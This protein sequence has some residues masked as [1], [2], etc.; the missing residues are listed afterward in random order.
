ME[1]PVIPISEAERAQGALTQA[2]AFAAITA[3]HEA[4]SVVLRGVFAADYIDA[5][6]REFAARYDGLDLSAM[7]ALA[8]QPPPNPIQQVGNGRFEIAL[9]MNGVFGQPSLFANPV[10]MKF[11]TPLLG[12]NMMRLS[13]VTAV[14][15][16]PGAAAQHIHRDHQQL[17]YEFAQIG[18]ALPLY[19]VNVS[20]P[21]IDIDSVT[22]PTGIW[23]GSHRWPEQQKATAEGMASIPF[24]RGDCVLIDYRTMH[25][26]LPN[27][28]Q[29]V[30]PILYLVYSREWFFDDNNHRGRAPLDISAEQIRLLAPELHPLMMRAY[31]QGGI[32]GA[33]LRPDN[34]PLSRHNPHDPFCQMA[35]N[36]RQAIGSRKVRAPRKDGAG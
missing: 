34:C 36:H 4:G 19:G 13:S 14:A 30:R 16:F 21:L 22:G 9:R 26:G 15:S 24:Q 11:L 28:S 3:L 12:G 27:A 20:V 32:K 5:L 23:P 25:T 8:Q 33:P 6:Y 7:S 17:F 35:V 10:L 2:S 18:P 29:T 31:Q 1:L